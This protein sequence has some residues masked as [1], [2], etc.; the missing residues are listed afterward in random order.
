MSATRL[1]SFAAPPINVAE[2]WRR[3]YVLH[4]QALSANTGFKFDPRSLR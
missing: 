2:L 1:Q 4:S 3:K